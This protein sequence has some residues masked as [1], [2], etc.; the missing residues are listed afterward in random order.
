MAVKHCVHNIWVVKKGIYLDSVSN[1]HGLELVK[2][3]AFASGSGI[4]L[5]Q[6]IVMTR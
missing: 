6:D 1:L 4:L 3:M 2:N 5:I